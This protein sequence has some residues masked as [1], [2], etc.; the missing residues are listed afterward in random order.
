M[1]GFLV[2]FFFLVETLI[3]LVSRSALLATL[4]TSASN[5]SDFFQ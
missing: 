2:R 5:A 1:S 4:A 3:I